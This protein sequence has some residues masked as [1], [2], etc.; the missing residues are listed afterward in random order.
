MLTN[1]NLVM[2]CDKLLAN[3]AKYWYGT[4]VQPASKDLL[5]QKTKQ[6]PKHYGTERMATY[7]KH[8]AEKRTVCD[9]VG[10]I[11]GFFW[12]EFA[13]HAIKYKNICPDVNADG[14]IALCTKKGDMSS[15][16]EKAGIILW[17]SG[18]VGVYVG[19]GYAIEARGFAYGV[20][21]T[22]VSTRGWQKWGML[23]EN[24]LIY[25]DAPTREP[26]M[27]IMTP[28]V[29]KRDTIRKG[30]KGDVVKYCQFRLLT[31]NKSCLPR[32]GADGDFGAE[33]D[34]AVRLFQRTKG[35]VVDGIVGPK[36]WAALGV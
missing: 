28:V 35:L 4:V 2:W 31:W 21:K 29:V 26:D 32:Y 11:K 8:I 16:P 1:K 36:T 20:V 10:M 19:G 3:G 30:D 6:Y 33:T 34:A 12:T 7:N 18:H 17:R 9:C 27:H 24:M 5:S 22:K 25:D 13:A 14:M 23:P 15:M